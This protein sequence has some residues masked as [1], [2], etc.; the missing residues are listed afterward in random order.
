MSEKTAA[1]PVGE[2]PAVAERVPELVVALLLMVF[3]IGVIADSIRVGIGWA[4]DG[5]RSGYFPFY[6]GL[7]LLAASATVFVK[8]LLTWRK[9]HAE[10]AKRSE[11]RSVVSV[12]IPMIVYVAAVSFLGIYLPS[13]LLIGYFMRHHGKFGWL[14]TFAVSVAVPLIVFLVFERWFLV[15]LAKGPIEQLLGL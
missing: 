1:D 14:A 12:L 13:A 7:L 8:T 9:N 5:P 15:P 3:A 4:D 2:E 11:L 10:F 6:I